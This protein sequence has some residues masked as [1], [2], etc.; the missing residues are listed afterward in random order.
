[1]DY[2]IIGVV[3]SQKFILISD[4]NKF[5]KPG[6]KSSVKD[7]TQLHYMTTFIPV[8]PKKLTRED[9]LKALSSLIF[10]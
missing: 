8:Y 3:L 6:D 10:P 7:M 4:L 2:Q 1:M 5:G 9:R